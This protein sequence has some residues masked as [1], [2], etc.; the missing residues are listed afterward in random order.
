MYKYY[1]KNNYKIMEFEFNSLNEFMNYLD[2]FVFSFPY[3]FY[4]QRKIFV[5]E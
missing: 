1:N 4:R 2:K 3:P 5:L